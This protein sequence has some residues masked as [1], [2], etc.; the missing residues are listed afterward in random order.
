MHIKG[1][2]WIEY[3]DLVTKRIVVLPIGAIDGHGPH[4]P[5]ATDTIIS[6]KL[7]QKLENHL[8]ILVL[9]AI[10]Y[11]QKTDPPASGGEFVGVT[12]LRASTLTNVVLDLLRA[13]Y[14]NGARRF[15]I[16][17]SHKVNIGPVREA[18]DLFFDNALD[19]RV[20]SVVWWDVVSEDTRNKIAEEN[21]VS[22]QD[23]HH[24]AMVETSIV[25]YLSPDS[26]RYDLVTDN[27]IP[28][29]ARYLIFPVP[30][31]LKTQSGVVYKAS[32]ASPEI[33]KR[34]VN[35]IVSNLVN[36]IKLELM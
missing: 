25:M 10:P 12:N 31:S 20:M 7:A 4:L 28:R 16:I 11:G 21:G 24:A 34:I 13:S 15:L 1:L 18:V 29:R 30:D 17:D 14:R 22:R 6:T 2:T 19:A 23:D 35:E 33:G 3:S 5:L 26:V 8:D 9:P 32:K 36:A 27:T